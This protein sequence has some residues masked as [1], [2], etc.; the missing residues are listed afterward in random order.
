MLTISKVTDI[1][2]QIKLTT[3]SQDL[4]QS[5][6]AQ[7]IRISENHVDID[8]FVTEELRPAA[9]KV[10]QNIEKAIKCIA[11][12]YDVTIHIK[13]MKPNEQVNRPRPLPQVQHIVA[14]SSCKGGVGKSTIAAS[15]ATSL[16]QQGLRVG[17]LDADIFGPSLPTLFKLPATT[18]KTQNNT[19]IPIE[20]NGLKL[21]SFGFLLGN[22]AAV[23]RGPI[24]TRYVQQL[25][26]G[27]DWGD[28]DYLIIDMPPG[29]GDVHLTI[30]QTIQL[31]GAL[32]VT[33]PHTL[34][35]IDVARGILMYEKVSV[36]ILGIVE[37]MAYF[38]DPAGQKHYIFGQ[39]NTNKLTSQFGITNIEEIAITPVLGEFEGESVFENPIDAT[40]K[41]LI[42]SVEKLDKN[43]NELPYVSFNDKAIYLEWPTG[44]KWA[45]DNRTLRL[46][47]QDALSVDEL[48]GKKLIK[49][50]NIPQ[51]IK[52]VQILPLGNYALGI[53]WS[54]GHSAGIYPY[55]LIQ[56]CASSTN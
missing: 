14:V 19:F 28:L 56:Q 20:K 48:T 2:R 47:S 15:M 51:D 10:T 45:V 52:P 54:D 43:K 36:P 1:L 44:E 42:T 25:L 32:I 7:N 40:A 9:Q 5:R 21:M 17:L 6:T 33:T 50:E 38:K 29:T 18:V 31:T 16:S 30:T 46:N 8:L 12:S 35:L 26:L 53:N 37:N 55:S 41:A 11:A 27:T 4:I 3:N 34:S 13:I 24:V 39:S 49:E 23:M 22:Q